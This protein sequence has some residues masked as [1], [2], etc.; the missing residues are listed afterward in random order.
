MLT[1]ILV[2]EEF[3]N[4]GLISI[5]GVCPAEKI[6]QLTLLKLKEFSLNMADIVGATTDGAR[7]MV[8]FGRLVPSLHQ[9]CYNHAIHLGITDVLFK[10]LP[11]NVAD[12]VPAENDDED[13]YNSDNYDSPENVDELEEN[14]YE[15]IRPDVQSALKRVRFIVKLF[16]KSP[17]KNTILQNHIKDNGD[18]ELSLIIDCKTRWN[19][20]EAMLQ[21]FIRTYDSVRLALTE[22]NLSQYL[23]DDAMDVLKD[24]QRALHPIIMAVEALSRR[25][26]TIITAEDVLRFLFETLSEELGPISQELYASIKT[27]ITDRRNKDLVSLMRY[28]KNKDLISSAELP[29]SPKNTINKLAVDLYV[30]LFGQNEIEADMVLF[31]EDE[32][33]RAESVVDNDAHLDLNPKLIN[34]A[35]TSVPKQIKSTDIRKVIKQY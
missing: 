4:L 8:E 31:E 3:V 22:L 17:V 32:N 35:M 7:V 6:Q 10:I 30:Q 23:M 29:I 27:R 13:D 9:T 12:S 25:D 2:L 33:N 18:K 16:K 26:A 21:Q 20:T 14:V 24:L 28:L 34:A 1:T 5:D 11:A 15:E 19:S